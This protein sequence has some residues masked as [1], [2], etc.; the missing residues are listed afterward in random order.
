[1]TSTPDGDWMA[2]LGDH[3]VELDAAGRLDGVGLFQ[4]IYGRKQLGGRRWRDIML[5]IASLA[6]PLALYWAIVIVFFYNLESWPE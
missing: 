3:G 4:A 1:L 2:G 6:N 5:A